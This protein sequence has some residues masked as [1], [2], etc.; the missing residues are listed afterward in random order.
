MLYDFVSLKIHLITKD[1]STRVHIHAELKSMAG[2]ISGRAPY[3][4]ETII[5]TRYNEQFPFSDLVGKGQRAGGVMTNDLL[6][7]AGKL[8]NGREY[9]S[10]RRTT[11]ELLTT[12]SNWD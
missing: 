11:D 1:I 5:H 9:S 7:T 10:A 12:V 8:L 4:F 6:I 2:N 3:S